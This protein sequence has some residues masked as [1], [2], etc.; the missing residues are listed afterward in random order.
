MDLLKDRED[1]FVVTDILHNRSDLGF[2][3]EIC[4]DFKSH[5]KQHPIF[6]HG[7]CGSGDHETVLLFFLVPHLVDT[8]IGAAEVRIVTVFGFN[9][10]QGQMLPVIIQGNGKVCKTRIVCDSDFHGHL[11]T[12]CSGY[13]FRRHRAA[14]KLCCQDG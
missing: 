14:G 12:G 2:A 10:L 4:R 5:R 8:H 3:N 11:F 13:R 6:F 9:A 7:I 1:R